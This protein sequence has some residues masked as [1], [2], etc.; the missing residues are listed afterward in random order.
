M[1]I[2]NLYNIIND[3]KEN[4][5]EGS[6]TAYLFES[7]IDKILKKVGDECSETIIDA[8]N[9]EKSELASEICDLTYHILVLMSALNLELSDV[10]N[11][12][13]QRTK[14]IGNLKKFNV[15]DKNS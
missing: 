13:I 15:V 2:E 10:E 1:V 11:I 5:A 4:P 8:K 3:R 12:L 14:K 6:Y 9:G 7:G